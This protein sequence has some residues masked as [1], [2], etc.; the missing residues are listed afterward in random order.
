VKV[1]VVD[2]EDDIRRIAS[3]SLTAVGGM[4]VC[5]AS[6]GPAAVERARLESPDVVLLDMMMPGMDGIATFQALREQP[7]TAGTP[8]VFL[9]AKSISLEEGRV[10][11]LGARGVLVKPFDPMTLPRLLKEMLHGS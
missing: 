10:R 8:V 3:L 7:E 5:E 9:T 6:S 2:D 4:D 11:K 1:L